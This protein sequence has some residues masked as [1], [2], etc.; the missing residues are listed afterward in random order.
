MEH[1]LCV[2][3]QAAAHL[4]RLGEEHA[5]AWPLSAVISTWE[6]L[7]S[8]FV[9]ELRVLDR[10]ARREMQEEAP[11]F[12]RL[13][14]FATAPGGDG[15]PWL[16]LPQTFNLQDPAEYFQVDILPRQQRMLDR[17]CWSLALR[18]GGALQGARAGEEPT[19]ATPPAGVPAGR[20]GQQAKDSREAAPQ[21]LGTPLTSKEVS[22]SMDH[23][24]KDPKTG[25]FLC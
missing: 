14:F 19:E 17:A 22:R 15:E 13:R 12:D 25:K 9:E 3:E 10:Q 20:V 6:E 7:W 11:S 4:L 2:W 5:H 23:R 24:P 1:G 18:K 8:R 16:R 21:L